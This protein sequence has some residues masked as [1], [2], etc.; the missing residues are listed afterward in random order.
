[1]KVVYQQ[2]GFMNEKLFQDY[3]FNMFIPN[4]MRKRQKN[5]YF[6]PALLIM[7]NL[8][9]HKKVIGCDQKDSYN[10]LAEYDLHVLFLV[11]HS[12]DQTQPLDLGIFANHK[13]LAQNVNRVPM[14]SE[15]SNMLH[16]VIV[17]IQKASTIS[18]IISAAGIVRKIEQV[19]S[20][21]VIC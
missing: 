3:F 6:G 19:N 2:K 13:R 14:L 7:D 5:Q 8:L 16:R 21:I 20:K 4:M 15:M 10:F 11:P 1:M 18:S 9:V 17:G 12:S